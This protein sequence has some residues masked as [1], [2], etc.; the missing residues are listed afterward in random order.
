M[1]CS[2]LYFTAS[3]VEFQEYKQDTVEF[4]N[5]QGILEQNLLPS[6]R[7]FGLVTDHGSFKKLMNQI[8]QLKSPKNCSEP[9][10]GPF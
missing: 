6:V 7:R 4:Q 3:A 1:L 2:V 5:Y 8:T 9:N 10:N